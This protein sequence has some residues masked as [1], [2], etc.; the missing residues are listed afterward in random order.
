MK[1]INKI[2]SDLESV[3]GSDREVETF[4]A[5]LEEIDTNLNAMGKQNFKSISIE[6]LTEYANAIDKMEKFGEES[7]EFTLQ[8]EEVTSD[9]SPGNFI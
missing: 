6:K 9:V 1:N 4:V 2:I 7:Q 8:F 5:L 3:L